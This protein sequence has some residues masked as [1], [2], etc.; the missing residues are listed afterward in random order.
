MKSEAACAHTG[1]YADELGERACVD[2]GVAMVKAAK[3]PG[4]RTT[5][6]RA[7]ASVFGAMGDT[8]GAMIDAEEGS[9]AA[10]MCSTELYKSLTKLGRDKLMGNTATAQAEARRLVAKA[11][12]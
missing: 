9:P 12:K 8:P 10:T 7:F 6:V 1:N 2:T 5:I 3:P 11:G 4:A